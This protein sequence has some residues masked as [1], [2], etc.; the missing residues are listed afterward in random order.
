M[1]AAGRA[2]HPDG[3]RRGVELR[4]VRS[5]PA[6]GVINVR[7][8][9]RIVVL[10][11]LPKVDGDNHDTHRGKRLVEMSVFVA[12][13]V[14]T[15]P[16]SAMN[17]KDRGERSRAV[18]LVHGGLIALPADLQVIHILRMDRNR[19]ARQTKLAGRAAISSQRQEQ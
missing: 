16:G 2:E 14:L 18:W 7:D 12:T 1:S 13:D 19:L 4:R 11:T 5:Q 8:G 15:R 9:I 3:L 10:R 17:I 6:K